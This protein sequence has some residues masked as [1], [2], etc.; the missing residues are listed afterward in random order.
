[1]SAYATVGTLFLFLSPW[2]HQADTPWA[3]RST[4]CPWP[5]RRPPS[6]R[7][8][9]SR[10][11]V[12]PLPSGTPPGLQRAIAAICN[13]SPPPNRSAPDSGGDHPIQVVTPG[14]KRRGLVQNP[15]CTRSAGPAGRRHRA[16]TQG[17]GRDVRTS[18]ANSYTSFFLPR[19]ST[20]ESR[21]KGSVRYPA[22]K[23]MSRFHDLS[24]ASVL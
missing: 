2:G 12:T 20:S 14:S 22:L 11:L 24:K 10:S 13:A 21:S 6:A 15:S 9:A 8:R 18:T 3:N 1:M 5:S 16:S 23:R 17:I 4:L 7:D 19:F